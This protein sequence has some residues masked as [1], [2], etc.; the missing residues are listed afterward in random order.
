MRRDSSLNPQAL[1]LRD[2][3]ASFQNQGVY[4]SDSKNME[5]Y[6]YWLRKI[7][8][9]SDTSWFGASEKEHWYPFSLRE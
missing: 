2:I 1:G 9:Y 4:Y 6:K 3:Q 7:Q 8:K 5:C